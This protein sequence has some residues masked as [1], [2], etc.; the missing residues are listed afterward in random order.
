[1]IFAEAAPVQSNQLGFH[2]RWLSIQLDEK[3][4][5]KNVFQSESVAIFSRGGG[6]LEDAIQTVKTFDSD[7]NP[8]EAHQTKYSKMKIKD[9][10]PVDQ[11][12]GYDVKEMFAEFQAGQK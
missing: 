11:W 12:F 10:E 3:G 1:M 6:L 5:I 9:F 7:G 4:I 2:W 8:L